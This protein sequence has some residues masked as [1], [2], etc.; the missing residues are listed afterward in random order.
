VSEPKGAPELVRDATTAFVVRNVVATAGASVRKLRL[1]GFTGVLITPLKPMP[2]SGRKL[3][4][5]LPVPAG[6]TQSMLDTAEV[7]LQ[8]LLAAS[9]VEYTDIRENG[10]MGVF[11]YSFDTTQEACRDLIGLLTGEDTRPRR[12]SFE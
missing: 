11:F 12:R 6:L 5:V 1:E 9:G 10:R 4:R 7:R 8:E 2:F 3:L